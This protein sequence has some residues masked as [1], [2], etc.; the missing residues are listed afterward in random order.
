MIVV[1][2]TLMMGA[3]VTWRSYLFVDVLTTLLVPKP[4]FRVNYVN[5][6]A[7]DALAP[8]VARSST[9]MVLTMYDNQV[10]FIPSIGKHFNIARHV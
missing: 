6:I 9:T 10:L 4:E 8:C 7:V 3:F 2:M 1:I 5:N